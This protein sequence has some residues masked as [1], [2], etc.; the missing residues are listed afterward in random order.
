MQVL[1]VSWESWKDLSRLVRSQAYLIWE[2]ARREWRDRNAGQLL[3]GLWLI[4]HPLILMA[5][6]LF[7][8][9][10]V[11]RMRTGSNESPLGY[12][13]Y[14]L[15]GL[16]PWLAVQEALNRSSSLIPSHA[17]LIK[18]VNF[19]VEVLPIKTIVVGLLPLLVSFTILILYAFVVQFIPQ[20]QPLAVPLGLHWTY[21]LLPLLIAVQV[22]GMTGLACVVA[23]LGAFVRDIKEVV[24]VACLI[25][26]YMLPVFYT[27]TMQN[28][29]YPLLGKVLYLNPF[30]YLIWCYQDVCYFGAIKHPWAW[31]VVLAGSGGLLGVGYALFQR[32]KLFFGQVL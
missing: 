18:Q 1:R 4:C 25:G 7:V 20:D 19:P 3:G 29:T 10:F 28:E 24:P 14:L 12:P 17:S 5:V 15:A 9:G 27:E 2:L 23:A 8:F 13:I 30:S 6:Y 11:F 22:I 21:L 26:I 32:M 16:I 31:V